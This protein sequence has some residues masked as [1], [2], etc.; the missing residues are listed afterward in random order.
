MRSIPIDDRAF[1]GWM[2]TM[3]PEPRVANRETGELSKDRATGETIWV[4]GVL[5]SRGRDSS[6]EQVTV[7]G[8][9]RGLSLHMPVRM[10]G[11]VA[12]SWEVDG[13]SGVSFRAQAMVPA[14]EVAS[15][16]GGRRAA[17]S[18]AAEGSG[19]AG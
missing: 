14:A 1:D 16:A 13:R 6:V 19:D 15:N 8:E 10:V 18:P 2:V 11:L 3:A 17:N 7:V 5:A 12:T 4:V 9:P